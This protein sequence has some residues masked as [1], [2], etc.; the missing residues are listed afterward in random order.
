MEDLLTLLRT[1]PTLTDGTRL[2]PAEAPLPALT[3]LAGTTSAT[4]AA[5]A[6]AGSD[7]V[8]AS[9]SSHSSTSNNETLQQQQ[10]Q[11]AE[12]NAE[13][14]A[15]NGAASTSSTAADA[16]GSSSSSRQGLRLELRDVSFGYA[17]GGMA[18]GGGRQVLK[19]VSLSAEPGESI[20][21]VGE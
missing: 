12:S 3:A 16:I 7:F 6:G 10:Q 21:I 5:A 18:S 11:E 13:R 1:P 19:G 9:S 15:S 14:R 17:E 2:L 20:A 8:H 4:A